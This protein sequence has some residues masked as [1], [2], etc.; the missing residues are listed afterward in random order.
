M[1]RRTSNGGKRY[2]GNSSTKQ[3][4]DLD[5]E[6]PACQIDEIKAEH[7]VSFTPDTKAEATRLGYGPCDKCI[8]D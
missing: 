4:H 3:V 6:K 8:G 1:A 5:N 2:L 7:I